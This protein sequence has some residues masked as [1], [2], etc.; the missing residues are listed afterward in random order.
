M[1]KNTTG[2]NDKYLKGIILTLQSGNTGYVH[3]CPNSRTFLDYLEKNKIFIITT[4]YTRKNDLL[5][6]IP[7]VDNDV[8]CS[9]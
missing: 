4:I 2:L 8:P 1:T 5:V 6:L 7:L 9:N 3:G